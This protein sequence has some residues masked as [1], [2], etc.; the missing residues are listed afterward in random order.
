MAIMPTILSD[1][2]F[3]EEVPATLT[4]RALR[5][6]LAVHDFMRASDI[7]AAGRVVCTLMLPHTTA[8]HAIDA[9]HRSMLDATSPQPLIAVCTV[10]AVEVIVAVVVASLRRKR[11]LRGAH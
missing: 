7:R 2:A 1:T 10:L 3:S 9:P 8:N 5:I 4:G 6:F 11:T